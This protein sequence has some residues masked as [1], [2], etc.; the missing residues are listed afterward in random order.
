MKPLFVSD[1]KREQPF[2]GFYNS[3]KEKIDR[4]LQSQVERHPA[5]VINPK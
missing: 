3:W 2:G 4:C 5:G 1:M